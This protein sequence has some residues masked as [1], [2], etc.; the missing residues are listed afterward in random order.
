MSEGRVPGPI[1]VYDHQQFVCRESREDELTYDEAASEPPGLTIVPYP[2]MTPGPIGYNDY[3]GDLANSGNRLGR[4]PD[5]LTAREQRQMRE[6]QQHFESNR[7]KTALGGLLRRAG[8]FAFAL[9]LVGVCT[10]A[11]Y[12]A[13]EEVTRVIAGLGAQRVKIEYDIILFFVPGML[14]TLLPAVVVIAMRAAGREVPPSWANPINGLY[15]VGVLV[16]IASCIIGS[17]AMTWV[18]ESRQF[19][20]CPGDSIQLFSQ[21]STWAM[22]PFLCKDDPRFE[23]LTLDQVRE[24]LGLP[25]TPSKR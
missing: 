13:Y 2:T 21:K 22:A 25:I 12:F 16:G 1:G 5:P 4:G 23:G 24:D 10:L 6:L 3:A 14:I 7:H 17:I 15:I 9:F 18:M 20:R 8:T 19:R 11:C